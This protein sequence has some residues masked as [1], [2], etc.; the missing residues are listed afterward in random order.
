MLSFQVS[1]LAPLLLI[2]PSVRQENSYLYL[3][4]EDSLPCP[5]RPLLQPLLNHFKFRKF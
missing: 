4:S 5:K 3:K 2:S 1:Q